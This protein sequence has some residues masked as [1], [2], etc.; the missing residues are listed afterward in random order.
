MKYLLLLLLFS[1]MHDIEIM[2]STNTVRPQ[3]TAIYYR[4]YLIKRLEEAFRVMSDSVFQQKIPYHQL[5]PLAFGSKSVQIAAD[6][7]RSERSL[8]ALFDAWKDFSMF[9]ETY[10]KQYATDFIELI[11]ILFD[12]AKPS[13]IKRNFKHV[14]NTLSLIDSLARPTCLPDLVVRKNEQELSQ[15]TTDH[16]ASRFYILKRLKKSIYFLEH[17]HKNNYRFQE[18]PLSRDHQYELINEIENFHHDRVRESVIQMCASKNLAP[19]LDLCNEVQQYRFAQDDSF[20]QEMLMNIFLVYK[21]I[22][23]KKGSHSADYQVI[24]EMNYILELYEKLKSMP[25]D[26]TLEAIDL[27]TDRLMMIQAHESS[28]TGKKI[29]LGLSSLCAV[30]GLGF[31]YYLLYKV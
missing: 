19:I 22:L 21:T 2:A 8:E 7:I 9:Q 12:I 14:E 16:I 4:Y 11:Y 15:V 18:S 20:L 24:H 13:C 31:F 6:R 3:T 23:F 1:C 5:P 26:E 27:V 30:A 10:S 28:P 17:M 25:L 29:L